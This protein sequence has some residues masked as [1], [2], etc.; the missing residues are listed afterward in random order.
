MI[1]LGITLKGAHWEDEAPDMQMEQTITV[2]E[3][4]YYEYFAPFAVT[5]DSSKIIEL[6][7]TGYSDVFFPF[8]DTDDYDIWVEKIEV[9]KSL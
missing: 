3:E 8:V 4:Y 6:F 1:K 5:G 9:Y 7:E 2:D